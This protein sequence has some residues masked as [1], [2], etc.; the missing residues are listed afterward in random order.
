MELN[1]DF[2]ERLK[3]GKKVYIGEA[4]EAVQIRSRRGSTSGFLVGF[5]HFNNPEEAGALRNQIV[6]VKTE[7]LPPLPDGEYY[8]H[9]M[10]GLRVVTD[11][12]IEL[13]KIT[14]ILETGS[15]DVYVVLPE[16]GKEILIPNIGT[17]VKEINLEASEMRIHLLNGL[18]PDQ[19][20]R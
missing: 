19:T 10:L 14:S 4:H 17:V 13:G 12:G 11:E 20:G 2:P 3:V 1:T 6:Y 9:Q 5:E 18:L 16:G 15:T 8:H 7:D